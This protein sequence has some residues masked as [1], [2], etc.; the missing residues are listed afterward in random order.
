MEKDKVKVKFTDDELQEGNLKENVL[1]VW[2]SRSFQFFIDIVRIGLLM[3]AILI[4]IRLTTNIEEVKILNSDVCK[5][6][7][8]KT[9]AVCLIQHEPSGDV[10][11]QVEINTSDWDN[12]FTP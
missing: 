3:F 7:E 4:F 2:K 6:C 1:R 8:N 5:V 9:G 11:R 12:M 10:V